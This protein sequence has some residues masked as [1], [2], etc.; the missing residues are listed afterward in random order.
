MDHEDKMKI[1]RVALKGGE[2]ACSSIDCSGPPA[3]VVLLGNLA[4]RT[5]GQLLWDG[6]NMRVTNNQAANEF[7]RR[8]YRR[9]WEL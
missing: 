2:P 1:M 9:G 8:E 3:E 7:V 6:P 4:I 5:E